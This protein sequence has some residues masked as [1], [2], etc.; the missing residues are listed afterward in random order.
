MARIGFSQSPLPPFAAPGHRNDQD[1]LECGNGAM[2]SHEYRTHF[3]LWAILAAPL[4]AGSDLRNMTAETKEILLNREVIAVDQDK[5][6][7][8]GA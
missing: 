4:I 8:A 2:Q 6:R 1:M 5:L 7:K 3:S